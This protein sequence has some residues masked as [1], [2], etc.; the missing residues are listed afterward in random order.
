MISQK[1]PTRL[2]PNP[3]LLY[4]SGLNFHGSLIVEKLEISNTIS[5]VRKIFGL[6]F[7]ENLITTSFNRT[8]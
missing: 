1:I 6:I 8:K 3:A 7:L 4:W 5:I 2:E